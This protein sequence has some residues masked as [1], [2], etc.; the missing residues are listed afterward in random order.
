MYL[1]DSQGRLVGHA[2]GTFVVLPDVPLEK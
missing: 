1:Y 2:T